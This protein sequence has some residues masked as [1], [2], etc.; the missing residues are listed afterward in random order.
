MIRLITI[1]LVGLIVLG[2]SHLA[3]AMTVQTFEGIP[4]T[5]LSYYGNQNLGN[6]LD[7]LSFGP[8]VT[9]L[10]KVRGGY[11]SL[12]YPPHSGNAVI[13]CPY[14]TPYIRVDFANPPNYVGAWYASS[15]DLFIGAYDASGNLIS[16]SYGSYSLQQD[17]HISVSSVSMNIAYVVFH[18]NGNYYVLD[19]L[20]YTPEPA[21]ICLVGLGAVML[22]RKR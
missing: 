19:D 10:D 13:H 6:Y 1:C 16:S 18:D 12:I 20:E 4:D 9:V 22:R 15:F 8:N 3:G 2:M 14:Q 17:S 5:Y 7:G 21:T 11:N